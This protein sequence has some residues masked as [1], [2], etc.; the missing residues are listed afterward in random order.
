VNLVGTSSS[1]VVSQAYSAGWEVA[2]FTWAGF[3]STLGFAFFA[4]IGFTFANFMAGEVKGEPSRAVLLGSMIGL[5]MAIIQG[6][7]YF[8]PWLYKFGFEFVNAWSY[9]FSVGAFPG[10]YY[11]S[12]PLYSTLNLV[13]M[14]QY[15]WLWIITGILMSSGFHLACVFGEIAICTR[16]IFAMSFDRTLPTLISKV[17]ERTHTP[18]VSVVL[19]VVIGFLFFYANTVLSW[20][21]GSTIWWA[22]LLS[23]LAFI[24]PGING[25]L[26]KRRKPEL[27]DV[28]A[29]F[30]KR[31]V[32]GF[33]VVG[34]L[35]VIWTVYAVAVTGTLIVTPILTSMLGVPTS[36]IVNYGIST[37]LNL[38]AAVLILGAIIYLLSKWYNKRR[39][40]DLDLLF[41]SLPPD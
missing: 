18:V 38:V 8:M 1:V 41:K 30:W 19:A 2:P 39:G 23:L 13:A 29:P 35:A 9:L 27:Y 10:Q 21:P 5:L 6:S 16:L 3:G 25:L 32:L 33:S 20:S 36:A 34:W 14:P 28:A 17:N 40:I 22:T 26:I 11:T 4:F 15:A 31:K 12:I 7:L 24:M 37:G